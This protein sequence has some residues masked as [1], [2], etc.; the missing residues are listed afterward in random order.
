M[1]VGTRDGPEGVKVECEDDDGEGGGG[2]E[3]EGSVF[4]L[5][6]IIAAHSAALE[7][8]SHSEL[9]TPRWKTPCSCGT[10]N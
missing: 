7:E 2:W 3:G 10:I 5:R 1:A 8:R 9:A 4:I 6:V